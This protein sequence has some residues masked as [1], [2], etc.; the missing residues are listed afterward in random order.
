M[1]EGNAIPIDS[2]SSV[3]MNEFRY[4]FAKNAGHPGLYRLNIPNNRW[5]DFIIDNEDV[6]LLTDADNIIDSMTVISSE[7]NKLYYDFIN[8]NKQYNIK[9]GQLQAVLSKYS[10]GDDHS[11]SVRNRF[12]QLQEQYF[13]FVNITS[14]K[15]IK[16]F[17]ARYIKTVQLPAFDVNLSV[18][19]QVA[20]QKSHFLDNIDFD[21]DDL[22]YSDAFNIKTVKYIALFINPKLSKKI[23]TNEYVSVVDTILNKAKVN[24]LVYQYIT[25]CLIDKFKE[26]GF[27]EVIDYIV[28][29][30]VIKDDLCLDEKLP[31]SIQQRIDQSKSFLVGVKVPHIIIPDSAG[32]K[33]DL[34]NINSEIILILFYA[35]WCPHCQRLL[36][37]INDL[38]MNQKEMKVKIL[39][40][41][42]D[43][44]KS[45]WLNY[46]R[47][48]NYNWINVSDLKGGYG[49]AVRD[50]KIY[51]TPAMFLV[52]NKK[53]LIAIPANIE[54]LK[55]YFN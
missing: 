38:Y 47:K 49:K 53:E 12:N 8:L 15:N 4:T 5:I 20:Y 34:E 46:L 31:N 51:A 54:D 16:S 30:Y 50:Y 3:G 25:E 10:G 42:L 14:Q 18:Q 24:Q 52:N 35:S 36:P 6:N 19:E 43:T 32:N 28:D 39:A 29:H 55:K 2:L 44:N 13:R 40:V 22:L 41:S 45:D 37:N 48:Y 26:L 23:L 1:R 33:I 21:D 7:S 9:T 27:S 11:I 17:V